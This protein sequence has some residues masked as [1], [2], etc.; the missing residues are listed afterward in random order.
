VNGQWVTWVIRQTGHGQRSWAH[1]V[2]LAHYEIGGHMV[3]GRRT[4]KRTDAANRNDR[5]CRQ[6]LKKVGADAEG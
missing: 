6:C 3:C 4:R 5:R 2:S 1:D